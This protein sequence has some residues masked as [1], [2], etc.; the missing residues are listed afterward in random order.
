MPAYYESCL[1]VLE[2]HFI[3][4]LQQTQYRP[5]PVAATVPGT[6]VA[7]VATATTQVRVMTPL[8]TAATG[9]A[10]VTTVP[11]PAQPVQQRLVR[12]YDVHQCY[13]VRFRYV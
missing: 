10:V 5:T 1:D 11:R 9:A 2:S 13:D 3:G 6:A 4:F 7:T 8:P 12:V